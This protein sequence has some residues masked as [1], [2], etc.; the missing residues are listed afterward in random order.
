MKSNVSS[1][2][3][4]SNKGTYKLSLCKKTTEAMTRK[5]MLSQ[6][7]KLLMQPKRLKLE[8]NLDDL[9]TKLLNSE[10]CD[11]KLP[12]SDD[13]KIGFVGEKGP[14]LKLSNE[15]ATFDD[16]GANESPS[17]LSTQEE[18]DEIKKKIAMYT[19]RNEI[20][21][22]KKSELQGLKTKWREAGRIVIEEIQEKIPA[23]HEDEI[24]AHFQIDP[25]LFQSE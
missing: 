23:K 18:I 5:R 25:G 1:V 22:K 20:H 11:I 3:S 15:D 4:K 7:S 2:S 19:K 17:N 8:P 14:C 6:Q 9:P 12:S 10:N 24:L 13:C 21:K 16:W